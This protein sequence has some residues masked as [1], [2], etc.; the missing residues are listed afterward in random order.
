[1]L[2]NQHEITMIIKMISNYEILYQNL[3]KTNEMIIVDDLST[4]QLNLSKS[5]QS[6]NPFF[7]TTIMR[8]PG[9]E[10][11][12]ARNKENGIG[13]AGHAKRDQLT[14]QL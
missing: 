3:K 5:I 4:D 6:K 8:R 2:K 11:I 14:K 10:N 1:M 12:P 9:S 7:F 13:N